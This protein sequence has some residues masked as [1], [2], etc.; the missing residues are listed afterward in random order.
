MKKSKEQSLFKDLKMSNF[1]MLRANKK[2]KKK[3]L[4]LI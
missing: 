2:F 3:K 1:Y 4:L